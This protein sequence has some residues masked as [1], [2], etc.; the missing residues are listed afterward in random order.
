MNL[1]NRKEK[2][3]IEGCLYS[4]CNLHFLFELYLIITMF[5]ESHVVCLLIRIDL[6]YC[7]NKHNR[8]HLSKSFPHSN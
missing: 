5:A 6:S 3:P 1:R 7:L 2:K 4:F 8:L